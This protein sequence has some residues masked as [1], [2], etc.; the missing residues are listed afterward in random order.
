MTQRSDRPEKEVDDLVVAQADDPT[1]WEE[2]AHVNPRRWK[3]NPSR[4]ELA[5]RFYVLSALHRL[6]A[7]ATLA[8]TEREGVDIAILDEAGKATTVAVKTVTG[9][10]RWRVEEIHARKDHYV[11]F[12]CFTSE[13]RNPHIPPDVFVLPSLT[14]EN[15]RLRQ[16]ATEIRGGCSGRRIEGARGVAP[17]RR[18]SS[19]RVASPAHPRDFI[20]V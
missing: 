3:V 6:G 19:H 10:W 12:V 1:A 15:A 18:A 16:H 20:F 8:L 4:M 9:G 7:E 11:V 13:I 17:A 2:D 5:A 14:L